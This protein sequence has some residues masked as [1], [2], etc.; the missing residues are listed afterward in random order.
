M[1]RLRALQ[2]MP[3]KAIAASGMSLDCC[4]ICDM[5]PRGFHLLP[6]TAAGIDSSRCKPHTVVSDM[7]T[8]ATMILTVFV[9]IYV[10]P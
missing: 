5:K 10:F 8:N 1:L 7:L 2:L 6:D 3:P 4:R 9:S